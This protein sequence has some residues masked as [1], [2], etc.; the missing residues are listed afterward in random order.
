MNPTPEQIKA[1]RGDLSTFQAIQMV[2]VTQ[3][4]WQ[5]YESGDQEMADKPHWQYF[6]KELKC[7]R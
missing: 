3:R 5:R 7:I 1:M 2:G 4:Q 6:I